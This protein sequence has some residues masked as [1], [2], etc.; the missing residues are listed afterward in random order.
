MSDA[1][2]LT[3]RELAETIADY[4]GK[5]VVYELPDKAESAGYS[6]ATKALLDCGKLKGTGWKSLYGMKDGLIRTIE[7]LK[8]II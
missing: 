5:R 7:I 3:L 4:V 1:S 6:K 8:E 2:D